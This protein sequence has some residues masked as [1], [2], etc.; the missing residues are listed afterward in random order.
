MGPHQHP[1]NI[2]GL[3]PSLQHIPLRNPGQENIHP[4]HLIHPWHP[5]SPVPQRERGSHQGERCWQQVGGCYFLESLVSSAIPAASKL[6]QPPSLEWSKRFSPGSCPLL[7][8]PTLLGWSGDRAGHPSGASP[9]PLCGAAGKETGK[10][11]SWLARDGFF[12]EQPD[13]ARVWEWVGA[14][15]LEPAGKAYLFLSNRVKGSQAKAGIAE[16][17]SRQPGAHPRPAAPGKPLLLCRAQPSKGTKH[18][19]PAAPSLSQPGRAKPGLA[20]AGRD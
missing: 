14:R 18:P 3:Q 12:S 5:A 16:S 6:C 1:R 20:G 13:S 11:S 4:W 2:R 17:R 9:G 8:L 19:L 15:M 7:T 10:N